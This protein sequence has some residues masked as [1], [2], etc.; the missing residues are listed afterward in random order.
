MSPL[1]NTRLAVLCAAALLLLAPAVEAVEHNDKHRPQPQARPK[2]KAAL[3]GQ[4]AGAPVYGPSDAVRA[5]AADMAERRGLDTA[6][7]VKQLAQ[8]R[9]IDS[10]QKLMMPARMGTA[11][12]WGAYHDR[13]VEPRRI[14][15]GAAFWQANMAALQRAEER[16]GVPPEIIVGILGV[17]TYYGRLT[18]GFRVIDALATLS[19]D[20]PGGRTDRSAFFRSELEEFLVLCARERSDPQLQRGSFA[21]AIGLAQFMPGS[22][23]RYAIDFDGD[24][25]VDLGA[26]A[27]DAIGSIA[28]Y[29]AQFGWQR[30][31]A[32]HYPVTPPPEGNGRTALLAPDILPSFSATQFGEHGALL[33]EAGRAHSGALALVAL[34]NG[35]RETSYVAGTQNFYA[36]TRYNWSSYYAMAVITLGEAVKQSR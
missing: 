11:K 21:G 14:G 3:S 34:Q 36:I 8:A 24:G 23:N 17:E 18:G 16:F 12:D 13:F 10:V 32:T 4:P 35:E 22:I 15:A 33:A 26:S 19:F 20:F 9:R 1:L 2:A 29:L 27:S 28:N 31:M 7:V 5:L 25:R 30:G 6:W